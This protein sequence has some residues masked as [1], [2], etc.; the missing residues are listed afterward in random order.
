MKYFKYLPNNW[1][2]S[3]AETNRIN[4]KLSLKT[5]LGKDIGI[6]SYNLLK[7]S[8]KSD[9]ECRLAYFDI[10]YSFTSLFIRGMLFILKTVKKYNLYNKAY[11][12][13]CKFLSRFTKREVFD[14]L[15]CWPKLLTLFCSSDLM[16]GERLFVYKLGYNFVSMCDRSYKSFYLPHS[17][18]KAYNWLS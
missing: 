1:E 17:K 15:I 13:S 14:I 11:C 9:F 7:N 18:C 8:N 16:L 12:Y 5:G 3:N 10:K 2:E 6:E 4:L